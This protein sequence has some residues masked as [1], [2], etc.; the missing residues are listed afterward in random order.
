MCLSHYIQLSLELT[1]YQMDTHGMPYFFV[2]ISAS[3]CK[4]TDYNFIVHF[5]S[6]FSNYLLHFYQSFDS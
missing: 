6:N 3:K 2:I 1:L 5:Y 4:F